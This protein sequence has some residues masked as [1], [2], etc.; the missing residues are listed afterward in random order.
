MTL[1]GWDVCLSPDITVV[2]ARGGIGQKAS[3]MRT[4][5]RGK[6]RDRA[7]MRAAGIQP[8]FPIGLAQSHYRSR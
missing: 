1:D 4:W 8:T 6:T 3:Q 2:Y 7:W 5:L